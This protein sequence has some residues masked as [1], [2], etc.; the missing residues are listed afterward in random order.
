M[1]K[2]KRTVKEKLLQAGLTLFSEYGYDATSTRMLAKEAGVTRS[3][4]AFYFETKEAYY[5]AVMEQALKTIHDFLNPLFEE[6]TNVY[7]NNQMTPE[8]PVNTARGF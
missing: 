1:G 2:E 7:A 4:I 3:S 6:I 8:G 5:K